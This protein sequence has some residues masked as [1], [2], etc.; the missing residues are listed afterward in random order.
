MFELLTRSILYTSGSFQIE[1][2]EFIIEHMDSQNGNYDLNFLKKH[3][4]RPRYLIYE[5]IKYNFQKKMPDTQCRV[6]NFSE[7]ANLEYLI[8]TLCAFIYFWKITCPVRLFNTLWLLENPEHWESKL[9]FIMPWFLTIFPNMYT[10]KLIVYFLLYFGHF[11]RWISLSRNR[12]IWPA[13]F[14]YLCLPCVL[15]V[16]ILLFD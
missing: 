16:I 10:K 13:F 3:L 7:Q 15:Q 8:I 12:T 11:W 2:D 5:R 6:T 1:E 9:V 4:S 14:A